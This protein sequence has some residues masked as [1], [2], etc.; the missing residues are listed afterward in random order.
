MRSQQLQVFEYSS[1][2]EKENSSERFCESRTED[3]RLTP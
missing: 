1:T 3:Y 2:C